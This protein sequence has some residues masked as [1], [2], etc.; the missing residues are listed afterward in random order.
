MTVLNAQTS[1]TQTTNASSL[2]AI[3]G[4]SLTLPEGVQ[5]SAL[6]IL[7]L[8]NPYAQGNDYPGGILGISVNGAVSPVQASFTYGIQNPPSTNRMPTTLVVAVPLTLQQQT[9]QA[10]WCGVRGSTVIIDS[11]AT[12]SI[13]I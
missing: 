8:P 11:P 13:V 2:T 9:I 7:N 4:L 5:V 6:V 10:L 3:P 12:L 1:G